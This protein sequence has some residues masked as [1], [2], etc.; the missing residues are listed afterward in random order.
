MTSAFSVVRNVAL[1]AAVVLAAPLAKPAEAEAKVC[2]TTT[3]ED[4][5]ACA[6]CSVGGCWGAA[7]SDGTN[8]V[9]TGGC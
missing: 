3:F 5:T 9:S 2:L 7:C 6:V 8:T 1:L 4:G